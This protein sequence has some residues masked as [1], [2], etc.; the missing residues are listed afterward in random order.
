VQLYQPPRPRLRRALDFFAAD[1]PRL[2]R[3]QGWALAVSALLL[4]V[5]SIGFTVLLHFKPE[6]VY[7][8]CSQQTLEQFRQMYSDAPP[9]QAANA[10]MSDGDRHLMAFG[11]Y[12]FNNVSI[13]FRTLASGLF[14]CVG[15][16][17][18]LISNGVLF[19]AIAGYLDNIGEGP[20]FWRFVVGHS[21][22]ELTAIVIA[23]AGGLPGNGDPRARPTLA[24]SG[25]RRIGSRMRPAR[26]WH[27]RDA[28]R[29][30]VRGSVL[31][32]AAG[33]ARPDQISGRR[34][35]VD[36]GHRVAMAWRP[37]S[38]PRGAGGRG[39]DACNCRE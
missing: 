18:V 1:F 25:A 11:F 32:V 16:I 9:V 10:S 34:D 38:A 31:V 23:G 6:L 5:P 39:L 24:R 21:G 28:G 27:F 37:R 22:L 36:P 15:A 8:L 4:A 26:P 12:I 2:V 17:F 30:R 35:R 7:T 3:A 29:S 33:R 13:G 19:G 20:Q 14:A